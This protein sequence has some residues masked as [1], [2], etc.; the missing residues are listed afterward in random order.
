MFVLFDY[1][2]KALAGRILSEADASLQVELDS[3]KRVKLKAQQVLL[4]FTAPQPAAVASMRAGR[5]KGIFCTR[6]RSAMRSSPV[7]QL[8]T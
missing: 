1:S 2:G 7:G 4:K 5:M 3:G 6:E 8:T